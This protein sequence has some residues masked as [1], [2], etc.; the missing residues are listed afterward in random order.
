VDEVFFDMN[1]FSIPVR[2]QFRLLDR[3]RAATGS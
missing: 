3:L 2:D 1:R